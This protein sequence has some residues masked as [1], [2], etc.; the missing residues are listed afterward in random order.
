MIKS[1]LKLLIVSLTYTALFVML[2]VIFMVIHWSIFG[3]YGAAD[4][5]MSVI[6][7]LS[8]DC[9]I[10]GYLSVVPALVCVA[11]CLVGTR[12]VT[13]GILDGWFAVSGL[14]IAGVYVLDTV[15]YGYWGFRLDIMPFFYF[16]TSPGAA[17]A[18]AQWYEIPL[19]LVAIA[20]I[21]YLIFK[22]LHCAA[23]AIQITPGTYKWLQTFVMLLVTG[24]LIIPIRGGVGLAPMNLSRAY[25]SSDNRLNHAAINPAFSLMY[26]ATHQNKDYERFS[27]MTDEEAQAAIRNYTESLR[28]SVSETTV[29]TTLTDIDRPDIWL[30]ILESFSSQLIPSAGGEPI[31]IGLDSIAN[32][33]LWFTNF[34]ANSFR[35]DRALT[36]ILSSFPALPTMSL[37]T[38]V[39]QAEKLPSIAAAFERKGYE[40]SYFYGGDINFANLKAYLVGAGYNKIVSESDF[41]ASLRTSK[42][43]VADGPLFDS[44]LQHSASGKPM[45]NVVQTSSSHEPF[46]VPYSN[47][48]YVDAPAKNAFA[49]TDSCL[50]AFVNGLKGSERWNRSLV[51]IVPDH[52]GAWPLDLPEPT[53]R[54]HVPLIITGGALTPALSGTRNTNP[55]SQADISATI[56]GHESPEFPFGRN[57]LN[58]SSAGFAVFSEP[59]ISCLVSRKDT[60]IYNIESATFSG[61]ANP[62]AREALKAYIQQQ[63]TAAGSL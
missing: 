38:H 63:Y 48:R 56:L 42:W 52:L 27:F 44:A 51:I 8:M 2:R 39:E 60:V 15:L 36:S 21:A 16:S 35:T 25:F 33:S 20:G 50:T 14:L 5:F 3:S 41:P 62:M 47:P 46:E 10:A 11:E 32:N 26:S 24:L 1:T 17:L 37:L 12:R 4:W 40:T 6:H 13:S 7:G 31:A 19:A 54:H 49:Y 22:A 55:G 30:I 53:D 57:L 34:Y 59:E 23:A 9:S 61:S 29:H 43:G 58:P 28:D 18:S 45:F